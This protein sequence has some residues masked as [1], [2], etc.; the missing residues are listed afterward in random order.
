MPVMTSLAEKRNEY[1]N[2]NNNATLDSLNELPEMPESC[3]E[4]LV[5]AEK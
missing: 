3:S 5:E 1:K 4:G 2:R